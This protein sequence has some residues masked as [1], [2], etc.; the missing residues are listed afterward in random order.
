[1]GPF[2]KLLPHLGRA[3]FH[4]QP[5]QWAHLDWP[6]SAVILC[7]PIHSCLM[8][9]RGQTMTKGCRNNSSHSLAASGEMKELRNE[10]LSLDSMDNS[11]M[12]LKKTTN[13]RASVTISEFIKYNPDTYRDECIN[14]KWEKGEMVKNQIQ[15]RLTGTYCASF[16]IINVEQQPSPAHLWVIF[17]PNKFYCLSNYTDLEKERIWPIYN[18]VNSPLFPGSQRPLALCY[19]LTSGHSIVHYHLHREKW[20][21]LKSIHLT[22]Y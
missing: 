20:V 9:D 10:S 15:Q 13:W 18:T 7:H 1:M 3:C 21:H 16:W 6:T 17:S 19:Y 2:P 11:Y 12:E 14:R 5:H 8:T 4:K 22:F